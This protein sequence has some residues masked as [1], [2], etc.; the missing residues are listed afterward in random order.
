VFDTSRPP[1]APTLTGVVTTN[2]IVVSPPRDTVMSVQAQCLVLLTL[3]SYAARRRAPTAP[4]AGPQ[5]TS[6]RHLTYLP[7]CV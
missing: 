6:S 4:P 5:T 1:T 7:R 3:S 2:H